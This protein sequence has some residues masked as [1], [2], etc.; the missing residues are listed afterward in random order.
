MKSMTMVPKHELGALSFVIF[1]TRVSESH[2]FSKCHQ[3][4]SFHHPIRLQAPHVSIPLP[5]KDKIINRPPT[6]QI[7]RSHQQLQAQLRGNLH[8]RHIL[9]ILILQIVVEIFTDFFEHNTARCASAR[10]DS[11]SGRLV[12]ESTLYCA[13]RAAS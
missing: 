1:I 7:I 8:I 10:Q 5:H 4:R 9:R 2:S 12:E 13:K 3:H 11:M 6:M